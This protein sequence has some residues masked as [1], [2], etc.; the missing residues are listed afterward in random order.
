ME[1]PKMAVIGIGATGAVLA[2]ALLRKYPETVL[3]GRN[4]LSGN[5]LL[6]KGISVSGAV[7]FKAPVPNLVTDIGALKSLHPE[8]IFIS[9]KTF[10]LPQ[11]LR[12][13]E[14]VYRPGVKIVST[15]NGLG[16]EDQIAEKF[17]TDAVFRMSLNYGASINSVGNI[18]VAFFNRPNHLG[19]LNEN[20]RN[21]G[22]RIARLLTDCGLDTEFV[23]D[24]KFYVWKKMIMK[25]TMASICAVTNKTIREAL[26]FAP[27]KEIADVCFKEALSVAQALGY[28]IEE[29]YLSSAVNYLMKAGVHRD[30]ICFDIE[31]KRPTE[32]EFLGEKIVEYGR[33]K[34]ISTPY[35][36]LMTNL[37]KA[38]EDRILNNQSPDDKTS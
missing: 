20:N 6:E 11:I 3:V 29:E 37:V 21:T 27:T 10:H 12:E 34:K 25:C 38:I 9:T 22:K 30:S 23:N 2:A 17:G 13:L 15:Q 1:Q 4:Q 26:M 7:N 32:I 35:F 18:D 36:S 19:S 16:P 24:I 5:I 28:S 8:V 14:A 33:Q 31:N